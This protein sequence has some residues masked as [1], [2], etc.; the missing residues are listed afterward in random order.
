MGVLADLESAMKTYI[1]GSAWWTALAIKPVVLIDDK[2]DVSTEIQKRVAETNCLVMIMAPRFER[3]AAPS[4]FR[5]MLD[6]QIHE[7][8]IMN[9]SAAG[10]GIPAAELALAVGLLLNGW[11]PSIPGG[12]ITWSALQCE[13]GQISDVEGDRVAYVVTCWTQAMLSMRTTA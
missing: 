2:F 5:V 13:S 3:T 11:V 8:V 10:S 1:E 4:E 9:R 12:K 6:I 7:K